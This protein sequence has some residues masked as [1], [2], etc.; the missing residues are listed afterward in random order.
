MTTLCRTLAVARHVAATQATPVTVVDAFTGGGALAWAAHVVP[1]Q[2]ST[3]GSFAAVPTATQ[4]TALGHDTASN[5]ESVPGLTDVW[6][7]QLDPFQRSASVDSPFEKK[8]VP[9]AVQLVGAEQATASSSLV[10]PG[11]GAATI[12]H[13]DPFHRCAS[14]REPPDEGT[15]PDRGAGRR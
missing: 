5:I 15:T 6:S 10:V 12:A 13:D 4:R 7:D 11:L 2:I 9:T 8:R 14:V 3:S 1:F